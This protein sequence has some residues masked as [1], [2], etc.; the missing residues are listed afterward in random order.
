[1]FIFTNYYLSIGEMYYSLL[2]V[3]KYFSLFLIEGFVRMLVFLVLKLVFS[4]LD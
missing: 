1:M 4:K 2:R 3:I